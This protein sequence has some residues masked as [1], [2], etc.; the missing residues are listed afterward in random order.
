MQTQ[1]IQYAIPARVFTAADLTTEE[2]KDLEPVVAPETPT[3]IFDVVSAV[4]RTH[5]I[6]LVERHQAQKTQPRTALQSAGNVVKITVNGAARTVGNAANFAW[7]TTH[8]SLAWLG[9]ANERTDAPCNA[10]IP[11]FEAYYAHKAELERRLAQKQSEYD[12]LRIEQLASG[13]TDAPADALA[14]PPVETVQP[15]HAQ[16]PTEVLPPFE[17]TDAQRT[18]LQD[19]L[20]LLVPDVV[21]QLQT[22]ATVKE[23][24]E[25]L[26]QRQHDLLRAKLVLAGVEVS[27][28][29]AR[30][31]LSSLLLV[32]L[33][34]LVAEH[35]ASAGGATANKRRR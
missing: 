30:A 18:T 19:A 12:N 23:A 13:L 17:L 14:Q 33:E 21:A 24:L 2:L 25:A 31:T 3:T 1:Q 15:D 5:Y 8:N 28:P 16:G 27:D 4:L 6:P 10:P 35:H 9:L 32:S 34:K 29:H 7:S 22:T 26:P 11:G 20:R